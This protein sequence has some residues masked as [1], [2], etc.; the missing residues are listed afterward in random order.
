[1]PRIAVVG[2]GVG[3]LHLG[4]LL[5][6]REVPVTLYAD[7]TPDEMRAGPRLMNTAGHW[8]PTREREQELGVNHWDDEYPRVAALNVTVTGELPLSF[9]AD[10]G[11]GPIA[12]DYRV[13]MSRLLEDFVERGGSVVYGAVSRESL[14]EISERHDLVVVSSGR[15]TMTELFP[16]IGERSPYNRPQRVLQISATKGVNLGTETR[17]IN[18]ELVPGVGELL[19]FPYLTA[20]GLYTIVYISAAADGPVPEMLD[21]DLAGN[22]ARDELNAVFQRVVTGYFP[23]S[24]EHVDW[25]VF[26]TVGPRYDIAGALTPT[27]RRPFAQLDNGRWVLAVG[28]VHTVNDPLLGQGA[29]SAS[30]CAFIVGDAI[31]EDSF[32]FDEAWCA[33]VAERMWARAGAA[34]GFTNTLLEVPPPPQVVEVLATA[35]QSQAMAETVGEFFGY[36]QRAWNVLATPTRTRNAIKRIAGEDALQNVLGALGAAAV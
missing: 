5:Q 22:E 28:D 10:L 20:D 4:L 15:G 35:S 19:L 6:Q 9:S 27:V 3:G 32:D 2:A 31:V 14:E 11:K 33:R 25:D 18:Y 24:A 13:S 16:K 7:R 17:S 36:P 29:N 30:A 21:A 12:V 1:M 8:V 34:V 23:W 26:S